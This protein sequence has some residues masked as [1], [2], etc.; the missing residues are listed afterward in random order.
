MT[1]FPTAEHLASWAGICPGQRES[2]GKS[3]SAKTRKGSP[4]LRTVRVECAYAASRSKGTYLSERFRQ[5]RRRRG[6]PRAIIAVGHDIL[7]TAWWLLST[8]KPYDDPGPEPPRRQTEDQT[9]QRALRQLE[10]LGFQRD[11]QSCGTS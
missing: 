8:G 6:E 3:K 5:V 4:S 9:R 2:A 7:T 1:V 11:A 10:R